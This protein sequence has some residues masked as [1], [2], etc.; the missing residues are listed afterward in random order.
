MKTE[1]INYGDNRTIHGTTK[2][3]IETDS[4]GIVV[5]VWFRCMSLPFKQRIVDNERAAEMNRMSDRVNDTYKLHAVKVEV[6]KNG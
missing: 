3:D 5:S 4:D 1:I 6:P 2:L